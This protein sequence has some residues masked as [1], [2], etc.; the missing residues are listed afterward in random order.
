[1]E[2]RVDAFP[3]AIVWGNPTNG[4]GYDLVLMGTAE[5]IQVD[6]DELQARLDAPEYARVAESLRAIGIGSAVQLLSTYAGS[7][8]D[9]APWLRDAA[10]NRD[11]NLRLQY[12]A[13][14]G[15]N[16]DDNGPIYREML[17]YAKF[18]AHLFT[19]STASVEALRKALDH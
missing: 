3:N 16:V 10:I 2:N 18:P 14:L 11:R 19:G 15:L 12:L 7:G 6:I 17:A 1:M 9:L 4:Q 5:P 8:V 13:G